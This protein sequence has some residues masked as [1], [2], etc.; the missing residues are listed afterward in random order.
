MYKY[1]CPRVLQ[2]DSYVQVSLAA[3][4]LVDLSSRLE[5]TLAEVEGAVRRQC[6]N[7]DAMQR[8][9]A[10]A[11]SALRHWQEHAQIVASVFFAQRPPSC[12]QARANSALVMGSEVPAEVPQVKAAASM[13]GIG[14]TVSQKG[15]EGPVTVSMIS[16]GGSLDREIRRHRESG[17]DRVYTVDSDPAIPSIGD[18]ILAVDGK[19][20][21]DVAHARELCLGLAG[22]LVTLLCRNAANQQLFSTTLTRRPKDAVEIV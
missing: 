7:L 11:C 17:R 5:S 2:V 3:F 10:S 9:N 4:R 8:E 15:C 22:T 14:M 19:A 16:S 13:C 12:P 1:S 20:I 21:L 18:Q 6:A